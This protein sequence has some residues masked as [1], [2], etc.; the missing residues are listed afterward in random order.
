[1]PNIRFS[2]EIYFREPSQSERVLCHLRNKNRLHHSNYISFSYEQFEENGC[3]HVIH[4]SYC[5]K[6]LLTVSF[7]R[8]V[9]HK[10]CGY[11]TLT[12]TSWIIV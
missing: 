8:L 4:N 3:Q 10:P 12:L 1:V 2:R 11:P 9:Y 6:R 5:R 7:Y